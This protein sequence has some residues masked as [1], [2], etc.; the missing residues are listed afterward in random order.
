[1]AVIKFIPEDFIVKEIPLATENRGPY[2]L[3]ILKKRNLTTL[4]SIGAVAAKIGVDFREIGFSGNKDKNAVTE[5]LISIRDVSRDRVEGLS[6]KGISLKFF[7]HSEKPLRIGDLEG[8]SFVITIRDMEPEKTKLRS[9]IRV[10]NLFGPQRFSNSNP[11][12]GLCIV[13]KEFRAAS[14]I[15]M[16]KDMAFGPVI[17]GFLASSPNDYVNALKQMPFPILKMYVH[18]LQSLIW[19]EAAAKCIEKGIEAGEI[20][21]VGFGTEIKDDVPGRIIAAILKKYGIS[22]RNF[23]VREIPS[24]SS[25]GSQRKA[26]IEV[27]ISIK[28]VSEDEL[29]P[30]RKKAVVEFS[31]PKSSYAT[32]VLR[33]LLG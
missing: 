11:D 6:I 22:Q 31:L 20:P 15:I 26:F 14:G 7:S 29:H 13:K 5:Q 19:N 30:G 33:E 32:V 1:M 8:N 21:I 10:P 24:V 18:A 2:S 17:K 9:R 3:F 23:I 28:S 27:E 4:E 12:I 16:E 25:E